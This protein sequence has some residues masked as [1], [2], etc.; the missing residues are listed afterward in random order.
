M[1]IVGCLMLTICAVAALSSAGCNADGYTPV[2]PD[3]ED[4]LEAPDGGTWLD[5]PDEGA[6]AA[7]P[8]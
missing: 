1:R 2:C 7:K 6:D 8:D 3:P 5:A 4:C